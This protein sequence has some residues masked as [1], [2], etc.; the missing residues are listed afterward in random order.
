MDNK[1]I[2]D[3]MTLLLLPSSLIGFVMLVVGMGNIGKNNAYR[4]FILFWALGV[5]ALY[6]VQTAVAE[7]PVNAMGFPLLGIFCWGIISAFQVGHMRMNSEQQR[8]TEEYEQYRSQ[9][10]DSRF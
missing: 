1:E 3:L 8:L 2:Y 9:N 10:R 5:S 7:Q 4:A 6:A